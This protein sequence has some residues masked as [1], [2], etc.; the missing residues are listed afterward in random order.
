M[1]SEQPEYVA[2]ISARAI[3]DAFDAGQVV[4]SKGPAKA[5]PWRVTTERA[6]LELRALLVNGYKYRTIAP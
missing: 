3:H 4:E 2:L 1:G 6:T 5:C